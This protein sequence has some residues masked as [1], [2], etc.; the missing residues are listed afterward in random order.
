MVRYKNRWIAFEVI[1]EPAGGFSAAGDSG[2]PALSAVTPVSIMNATRESIEENF[3]VFGAA[4]FS[5][6][7]RV[8]LW[9]PHTRLGVL[10]SPAAHASLTIAALTFVTSLG[11]TPAVLHAFHAGGTLRK[12]QEAAVSYL[13]MFLITATATAARMAAAPHPSAAAAAPASIQGAVDECKRKVAAL[14]EAAGEGR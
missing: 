13:S 11:G 9:N 14:A 7:L 3:G 8:E 6:G 2:P 4:K 12:C 5:R 10:K 1:V